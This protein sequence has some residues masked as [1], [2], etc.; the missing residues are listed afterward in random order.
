LEFV[1]PFDPPRKQTR[2]IAQSLATLPPSAQT[3]HSERGKPTLFPQLRSCE[4]VGLRSRGISLRLI[5]QASLLHRVI[6]ATSQNIHPYNSKKFLNNSLPD[7]VKTD[8]G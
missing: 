7:S 4:V 5:A 6:L 3:C 2:F 8:S 1:P